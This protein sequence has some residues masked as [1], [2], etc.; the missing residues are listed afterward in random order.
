[1]KK[2]IK[3]AAIVLVFLSLLLFL[4]YKAY[5]IRKIKDHATQ[6]IRIL[7]P[8]PFNF[9][10]DVPETGGVSVVID[11]FAPDCEHC[12]YMARQL[13]SHIGELRNARLLMITP[14]DR[15]EAESFMKGYGLDTLNSVH[16]GLDSGFLF[17]RTFGTASIPSFFIYNRHQQLVAHFEGET[18]IGNI[19]HAIN[20]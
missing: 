10:R 7:P 9:T 12:Q 2:K 15:K 14:A 4:G 20:E 6:L 5:K 18:K 1:M 17:F 13:A 11:Y 16:L 8:L 19:I 3:F